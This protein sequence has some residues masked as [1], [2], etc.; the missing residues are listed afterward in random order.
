MSRLSLKWTTYVKL[1]EITYVIT[2]AFE[3]LIQLCILKQT[4]FILRNCKIKLI[5]SSDSI[6]SKYV[7]LLYFRLCFCDFLSKDFWYFFK[8]L[9]NT[10]LYKV[11]F[12]AQE[13]LF[14]IQ[15]Y[16]IDS[17]C[18]KSVRFKAPD[19]ASHPGGLIFG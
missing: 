16:K 18:S 6:K 2:S 12:L 17:N 19:V 11:L 7:P 15:S 1:I 8:S 10:K 3:N 5:F 14:S 13:Q 9:F 4:R